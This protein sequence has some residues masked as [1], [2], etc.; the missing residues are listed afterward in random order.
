MALL[1]LLM[2]TTFHASAATQTLAAYDLVLVDMKGRKTVLGSLPES[3]FAPR[4][5]PDGKQVAFELRDASARPALA[6]ERLWVAEL[7][8]PERRRAL[9]MVGT[10][11]NWAPLWSPDGQR[12]VFLVSGSG[13]DTLYWRRADGTGEAERLV[14][15]LSAEGMTADGGKLAFITLTG[16][17]DYGI[18][19][20]DL[21]TKVTTAVVDRHGSEQHSS[22]VSP[23]GRWVAYASNESGRH[24]IWIEPMTTGKRYRL[25]EGGGSHPVW[26]PDGRHL[27][28]DKDSQLFSVDI[29]LRG[30]VPKANQPRA[31]PITGFQ[32]GYR[33]RQYDLMPD[34]K[35]FLMLFT[36]GMR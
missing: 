23:D 21:A 14:E 16:D 24:E 18:F 7:A 20:L 15:G 11:R 34:G 4:V 31:L 36:H 9:P 6:P 28:F 5:S 29:D 19:L 1:S 8:H 32:Q 33:R 27:Y 22:H 13:P 35:Q 2:L 26:S 10:G 25:T 3:V 17:R 30:A 12:L